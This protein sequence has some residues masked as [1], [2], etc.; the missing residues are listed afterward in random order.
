MTD[1][2]LA[3]RL[4]FSLLSGMVVGLERQWHHKHAG[5][6]TNTLVATG[7]TA[8][9]LVSQHGF[10]PNSNPAQVAAG[11]VTG[12]GF[13]GAGV[14][15][16]RGGSV[17]G[18]NSAATLWASASMGLAIGAGYYKLAA[19]VLIAVLAI[20]LLLQRL[21]NWIDSRSGLITP[22]LSYHLLV[23]FVPAAAD[24]IRSTWSSFASQA[25]VSVVRYRETVK[26]SSE[27]MLEI[28]FGL[29]EAQA[30][31]LPLLGQKL[32]ATQGVTQAEWSQETTA[33]GE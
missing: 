31:K 20:Q 4:F 21:A 3:G 25:G 7:A 16:R 28:S 32:L 10:G 19:L 23:S 2:E 22:N 12:I 24:N 5:V 1:I 26:G 27:C 11:V 15:M 30:P 6:K 33:E 29:S 9:A 8:F 18:I 17:Q 14:I 13:I